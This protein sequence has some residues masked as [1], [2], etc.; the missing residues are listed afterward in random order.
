MLDFVPKHPALMDRPSQFVFWLVT[1]LR[2]IFVGS[3]IYLVDEIVDLGTSHFILSCA[4]VFATCAASWLAFTGLTSL[5]FVLCSLGIYS[6]YQVAFVILEF[7]PRSSP[8]ALYSYLQH[9][10]LIFIVAILSAMLT[11]MFWR[12]RATV[13]A[14]TLVLASG[15]I[16]LLSGHRNFHLDTPKVINSMAWA[17]GVEH[18][19]MLVI[20]GVTSL[21]LIATYLF[22]STLPG[23]PV[24]S[25]TS[26][27]SIAH[28][29]N[30]SKLHRLAAII[31]ICVI[32]LLI[33]KKI[34]SHYTIVSAALTTNGVGEEN[35]P[36][37]SPLGFHS[38]LGSTNQ[39][40]ALVRLEG[41]Y[42]TNPYSPMVYLRESA[43][44][45]YN[46]HEMVLADPAYDR[47]ITRTRPE[48]A[49]TGK[50][51]AELQY[52]MPLLQS[53][54]LLTEHENAFGIDYPLSFVRLKNPNKARFRSSYRAYSMVPSF[55]TASIMFSGVGDPRWDQATKEHYLKTTS[56]DRYK[57][58][59][60]SLTKDIGLPVPKVRALV[61]YLSQ[62]ATYTL[63][64]NHQ[65]KPEDDQVAPFLF[66]DLRGYCV[67]F[68]H[69]T[70]YMARAIGLPARIGTGYLTDLSQA[71]DGHILLRMSD[72]H[73]WAEVYV[74]SYGWLPFDTQ[75]SKVESHAETTVDQ[76][77]LE[78]LMGL[79]GPSEEILSEKNS[80]NESGLREEKIFSFPNP[81]YFVYLASALLLL[82]ALLKLYLREGWRLPA[83]GATKAYRAYISS[84]SLLTDIG[85][86]RSTAETRH[87]FRARV[88][89]K[90]G[91][92]WLATTETIT[93]SKYAQS[94][95]EAAD[96]SAVINEERQRASEISVG[97]R[98]LAFLNPVSIFEIIFGRRW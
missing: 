37:L 55:D 54:F 27:S 4:A 63:T 80:R 71:K 94:P 81:I 88:S 83:S 26:S 72:R 73:A 44:S 84:V 46:G 9:G 40:A 95:L 11:W 74:Q 18:I 91:G 12:V 36:G 97:R 5:G 50:E 32:T 7:L 68:A 45:E 51:D 8:L 41:D 56:D 42:N 33:S 43:L 48:E 92:S 30:H 19:T 58:L 35:T 87:E 59:A 70:V 66:G 62:N 20:F 15:C 31:L 14:E 96:V 53:I 28:N 89:Q 75:P 90:F 3:L 10:N 17:M 86:R 77:M 47:D 34:N 79:V 49:F 57:S 29:L 69:A 21:A 24:A 61:D 64:P 60:M 6:A 52:R 85:I 23:R 38:A 22:Y 16:Y 39:P 65:V 78:E 98:I 67:H 82:L 25:E 93:S 13:S 76:K 1:A 2:A